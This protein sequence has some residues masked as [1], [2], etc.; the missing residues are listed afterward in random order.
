MVYRNL[1]VGLLCSFFGGTCYGMDSLSVVGRTRYEKNLIQDAIC[2][3]QEKLKRVGHEYKA[4][5]DLPGAQE[6]ELINYAE[7]LLIFGEC[8]PGDRKDYS[9]LCSFLDAERFK[10]PEQESLFQYDG[11]LNEDVKATRQG[12]QAIMSIKNAHA[13][14]YDDISERRLTTKERS[15]KGIFTKGQRNLSGL[16]LCFPQKVY[17]KKVQ[18]AIK[19]AKKM[20]F[21]DAQRLRNGEG[22]KKTNKMEQLKHKGNM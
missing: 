17:E 8:D 19:V 9:Y 15:V 22:L 7:D 20:F 21:E 16:A 18:G 2:N 13:R 14:L 5:T 3:A 4:C 11:I 6:G 10:Q 12:V 1:I